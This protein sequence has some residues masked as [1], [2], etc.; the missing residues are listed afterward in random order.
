MLRVE[1]SGS[2]LRV[3]LDRPEVRNALND[4]L[5]AELSKVFTSVDSSVRAVVLA[6]EGKSFCSGGD[7]DWMRKAAGYTEEENY[8]D[9]MKIGRLFEMIANCPAFVIARVHGAAFGGGSGLAAS[10]D[11]AIA[12]E[13]TNFA[14][15]EVKLGLIPATISVFVVP[16]IGAGNARW[17]FTTGEA[18]DA[19][20]ALR[21]GLV[22]EVTNIVDLD[23]AVERKIA[24]I[25]KVG[26][27]AVTACKQ[28][29]LDGPYD[30][31]KAARMLAAARA[32]EEGKEG[33]NAFLEKRPASFM[34]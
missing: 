3:T 24:A 7:L 19:Q 27:K 4:E 28:I 17:L 22:H 11:V 6:G 25:L 16:K 26:P 21:I 20:T 33:V 13:N 29:C 15:S 32:G 10:C 18:F 1:K 5:I 9:A 31:E 12:E 30:M 23:A 14:F 2:V 34:E 8:Q